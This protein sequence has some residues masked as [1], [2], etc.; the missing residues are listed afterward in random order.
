[1]MGMHLN[2]VGIMKGIFVDG[3]GK[4]ATSSIKMSLNTS[5]G[6][7][8]DLNSSGI[9]PLSLRYSLVVYSCIWK[10]FEVVSHIQLRA[11]LCVVAIM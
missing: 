6:F 5:V 9:A 11:V 10:H 8:S 1:M 2:N 7:D 4:T 3:V